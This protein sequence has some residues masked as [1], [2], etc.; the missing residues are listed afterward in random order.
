MKRRALA[1]A[2]IAAVLPIASVVN[3]APAAASN[4]TYPATSQPYFMRI[5]PAQTT[6]IKHGASITVSVRLLKGS[7]LCGGQ[8]IYLYVHGIRD[9]VGS[10]PT[11]HI[12]RTGTTDSNGLVRWTY[13][14]QQSD[15]RF[16]GYLEGSGGQVNSPKGLVQVRG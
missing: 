3:A 15:F 5:S 9:F 8:H 12:S 7:L 13:T 1:I 14:N 2:A 10:T 6:V 11:Y 4:C 16:Y